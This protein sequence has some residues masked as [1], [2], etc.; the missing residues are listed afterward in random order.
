MKNLKLFAIA[1]GLNVFF[2]FASAADGL[3]DNPLGVLFGS[4][5]IGG[6]FTVAEMAILAVISIFWADKAKKFREF[7]LNPSEE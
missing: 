4:V 2:V 3:F 1:M 6:L 5:I 7:C